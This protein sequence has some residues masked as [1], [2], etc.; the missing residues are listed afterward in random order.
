MIMTLNDVT[1]DF[2]KV[3]LSPCYLY[4]SKETGSEVKCIAVNY[5]LS[6]FR[7]SLTVRM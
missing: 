1:F 6:S 2:L 4:E 3:L 5:E 7:L